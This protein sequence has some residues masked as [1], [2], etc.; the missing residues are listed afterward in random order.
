MG[1]AN[2]TMWSILSD[3]LRPD[4]LTPW[5]LGM[6]FGVFVGATPGL[7]A[8]MAIALIVPI[9][10]HLDP[11]AGL[12]M[13]L[14]V[15]FTAIFAGD[16]PATYL[17]I[18]GTPASGVAVL[19]AHELAKR[20]KCAL[21]MRVNLVCSAIGGMTGVLLLIFIAPQLA[22]F[23]LGFFTFER[24]WLAVAGLSISALVSRGN[25]VRGL[26]SAAIGVALSMVGSDEVTNAPRYTFGWNELRQSSQ[27]FMIPIM[28]GLFGLS[29]VI[30]G[31]L[32]GPAMQADVVR[33][34]QPASWLE[35]LGHVWRHKARMLFSSIFGT[36]VG[37]LPGA[38]ADVAAWGAYGIAKKTSRNSAEFGQGAIEGVV[39]PTSA[40][41]AAVA[42]AWIPALVFGVPGDSITAIVLGA[43]LMYDITPG[44]NIFLENADA[45]RSLFAI[46]IITQILLLPAGLFGIKAFDWIMRLPRPIVQVIV[47]LFSVVG[48]YALHNSFWDV[49]IMFV[50]GLVGW[51]LE[52][53]RVPLAPLILGFILGPMVEENLR[54]GLIASDGSLAPF[55]TRP[56]CASLFAILVVAFAAGPVVRLA[57]RRGASEKRSGI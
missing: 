18:P 33:D 7:T 15:S 5:M 22:R 8:T 12:A 57:R 56:I 21:A 53:Q 25:I 23:G 34:S 14:G 52:S 9:S 39:A 41:N 48:A 32:Q 26:L 47:V 16:I 29:E 42:G 2:L 13:I 17:R 43:L 11:S 51:Y 1:A 24:F 49:W 20:G 19:D 45:M 46:A 36:L 35:V 54:K 31:V 37:A 38:G 55:F 27:E 50:F 6:M 3:I 28:I 30:R 40:N 44:P 4:V 10:F